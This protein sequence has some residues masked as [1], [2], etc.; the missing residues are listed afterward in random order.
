MRCSI[1][2]DCYNEVS[3]HTPFIT[4]VPWKGERDILSEFFE[5]FARDNVSQLRLR[6]IFAGSF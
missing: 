2:I 3:D 1:I 4:P 6:K 5:S